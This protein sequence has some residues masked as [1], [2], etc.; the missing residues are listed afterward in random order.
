M[1][2][3][4]CKAA[5]KAVIYLGSN[6][7]DIRSGIKQIANAIGEN[8]HTVGKLLQK[9]V[10]HDV[11][12]SVKGPHG[13]FYVTPAQLE[14]PIIAIVEAID[15]IHVFKTCSLGLPECNDERPCPFHNDYKAIRDAYLSLL[16]KR[17][18]AE[19]TKGIGTTLYLT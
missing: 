19:L 5:I 18:I 2:S 7:T 17:S 14:H 8:E 1:L 12:C 9:L 11:I 13:G 16:S 4:S 6:E 15:G 3:I 10:H